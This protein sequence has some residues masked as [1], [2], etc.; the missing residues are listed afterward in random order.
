[1]SLYP[2]SLNLLNRLCLVVGGGKVAERKIKSLLN[3]GANV[4]LISPDATPNLQALAAD[5]LLDWRQAAY[6]PDGTETLDGV[7]L[8]I[9]CTDNRAVNAGVVSEAAARQLLILCADDPDAGNFVSAAQIARGDLVLTVSTGGGS[10]TLVA[11]LRERLE[12]EFGPEWAKLVEMIGKVRDI[13]KTNPTEAGRKEVMRRVLDDPEV[14][15]LLRDGKLLEAETRI[16][17]CLS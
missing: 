5:G 15:Q 17:A 4:R 6:A 7:F 3:A 9:A 2:I 13:V 11:V 16:R 12:A 1:M 14:H 10:P 8:V